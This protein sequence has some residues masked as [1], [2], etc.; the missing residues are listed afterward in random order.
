MRGG[1]VTMIIRRRHTANFTT[2]G[3][4]LFEDE[5]LAADEVGILAY[6]LS[7]PHDWE[8]RRPALMRRWSIGGTAMKRVVHSWMRY[9]WCQ[10]EKVRLPNGTFHVVYEIRDEPG[11][12]LSEA[13]VREALSLVSS[14]AVSGGPPSEDPLEQG[15]DHPY[16]TASPPP[17]EPGVDDQGVVTGGWSKEDLPRTDS[18]RTDSVQKSEREYAHARA[19]HALSL[20]EFKR[21]YPTAASDDQGRIDRAW[22]ALAFDEAQAALDGIVPFLEKLKRDKRTTVP[23]AWKYLEEKRWTLLETK[24]AIGTVCLPRDG[25]EAKAL[26]VLY[27]VAGKQEFFHTVMRK[28]D[29]IWYRGAITAR[30]LALAEAPKEADWIAL[31]YQQAKSWDNFVGEFLTVTRS[32]LKQGARAP[33]PWPPARDGKVYATGPPDAPLMTDEDDQA[34][35]REMERG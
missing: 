11:R 6:L 12:E 30:V 28:P 23:A 24:A 33:W 7:R 17:C 5:R 25:V 4:A 35:A 15:A 3:N 18:P 29:G 27:A 20:A 8:V 21:R 2:I 26:A 10:A 16:A 9:G 14:E 19:K 32:P 1:N 22:F 31:S 34:L 13:E